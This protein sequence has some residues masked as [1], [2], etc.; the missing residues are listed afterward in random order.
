MCKA[1]PKLLIG[2]LALPTAA[3]AQAAR[4]E[5]ANDQPFFR[6]QEVIRISRADLKGEG[7]SIP[8]F[9]LHK[10]RVTAQVIHEAGAHSWSAVLLP[11]S[12][13]PHGRSS[14]QVGWTRSRQTEPES[15]VCNVRL[16][17][18]STTGTPTPNINHESRLRDSKQSIANPTYQMEGP[19]I[20]ND[21]FVLRM[22]FD[23]RNG[24]DLYGKLTSQPVSS[25][26]GLGG[27][28]HQL[29]AWGMDI[30]KTGDSIGAGGL[31]VDEAARLSR[32]GDADVTTFDHLYDGPLGAAFRLSFEG[33]DV[34]SRKE[35]G[36]E[37]LTIDAGDFFITDTV[38]VPLDSGQKLVTG[39]PNFDPAIKLIHTVHNPQISSISTWGPQAE[40]TGTKLGLAIF[41]ASAD[42]AAI[43]SSSAGQDGVP[44]SS[45]VVLQPRAATVR[46]SIAVCWEQT[47]GRFATEAGFRDYIQRVA[48]RL[49]H[50]IKV[51]IF[52]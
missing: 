27:S 34:G 42:F 1:L 15:P 24:K 43:G 33:W 10:K 41:F 2:F 50:P 12:L 18:R 51:R 5:V 36:E 17:L 35:N 37:L 31:A 3:I 30:L 11:V 26:I 21:K 44:N 19:G 25:R 29:Q 6:D 20:E 13:P 32:L 40:G 4:I 9:Y 45:Y 8:T 28:W 52:E 22:F 39:L 14:L 47:D 16:S 46:L 38:T 7:D 23:P 49:A 48:D